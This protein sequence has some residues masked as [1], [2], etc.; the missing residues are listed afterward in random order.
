[1]RFVKGILLATAC[2][3][4]GGYLG[5]VEVMEVSLPLSLVYCILLIIVD[6]LLSVRE[7]HHVPHVKL[8]LRAVPFHREFPIHIVKNIELP[9][10]RLDMIKRYLLC[11]KFSIDLDLFVPGM[12][13]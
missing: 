4:I 10:N 3:I 12:N 9:P 6:F 5:G 2:S 11:Y 13:P 8:T 7:N 1:M